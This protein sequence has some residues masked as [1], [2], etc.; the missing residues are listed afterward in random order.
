[1]KD[2]NDNVSYQ[3]LQ[4]KHIRIT[5]KLLNKINEKNDEIAKTRDQNV[6]LFDI[7]AKI[8]EDVSLETKAY[9]DQYHEEDVD[10]RELGILDGRYEMAMQIENNIPMPT[11]KLS[12]WRDILNKMEIGHSIVLEDGI[13]GLTII[14][15]LEKIRRIFNENNCVFRISFHYLN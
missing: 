14:S 9:K 1:M 11:T 2:T 12:M 13:N 15:N 3:E 5:A 4:D 10:S 8:K 6:S 7:I